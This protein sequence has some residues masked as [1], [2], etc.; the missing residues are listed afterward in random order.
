[1]EQHFVTD[2]MKNKERE[3]LFKTIMLILVGLMLVLVAI[4]IVA[5]FHFDI[6][7]LIVLGAG[8]I[9]FVIGILGLKKVLLHD[10]AE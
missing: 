8:G 5:A 10:K 9:C 3:R 2:Y 7:P 4:F 6:L 1:M